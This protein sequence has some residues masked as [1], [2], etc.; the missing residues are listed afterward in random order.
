MARIQS[1]I[2]NVI[3]KGFSINNEFMLS[4]DT[5]KDK[6]LAVFNNFGVG[7]KLFAPETNDMTVNVGTTAGGK[8]QVLCEEINLPGVTSST[9]VARGIYQGVD[10]K[11]AHTKT[12]NDLNMVFLLDVDLLPL[13]F[14]QTW[15]NF[16]YEGSDSTGK[17]KSQTYTTKY[18]DDY[19]LNMYIQ[20]FEKIPDKINKDLPTYNGVYQLINA[21]PLTISSIPL[22]SGAS[23]LTRVS[24]TMAYERWIFKHPPN[25]NYSQ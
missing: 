21:Y 18:Y 20:K 17:S 9:N 3:G 10:F 4:F 24:V 25:N 12:Y 19:T 6:L 23:A 5:P 15:F 8:I 7:A 13:R 1:F 11:Y 14:F 2:D 22:N 16:I